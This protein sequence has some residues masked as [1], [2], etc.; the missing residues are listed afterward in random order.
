MQLTRR[1]AFCA[2]HRLH[3]GSLSE[4]QNRELFGKCNNPYGHGHNYV[5]HVTVRGERDPA[6][7]MLVGRDELD[8]LVQEEVLRRVDHSDLNADVADF[9]DLNPTTENLAKVVGG[10][11]CRAWRTRFPAAGPRLSRVRLEETARNTF[12]LELETADERQNG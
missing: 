3:V 11:L 2:S 4:E 7:G 6:T 9:A 12:T 8:A 5:L 1:Y 10:W